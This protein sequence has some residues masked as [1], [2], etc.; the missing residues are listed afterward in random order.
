MSGFPQTSTSATS[1]L[2]ADNSSS[3]GAVVQHSIASKY[4]LTP[5][6][7]A[8]GLPID[9]HTREPDDA[10][11]NPDPL[12]DR[13]VDKG[14]HIFTARGLGNLGCLFIIAAGFLTLFAG[15]PIFSHFT[16]HKQ[17]TQ[18]AFNLGGTNA[19]GQ[20]PL[21]SGNFALIDE[22]T[23]KDAYTKASYET[24]EEW[25]LVFSDEFN[26]DGRSFYAGDDPFW[27]AVDFHYWGTNDLEWYDPGQI[28]TGG[29]SLLI[30][31]EQ[32]NPDNN[33]NLAYKNKFCFTGGLIE[34]AVTLPGSNTVGGLWPA[35]WAMGNLGR[36]GYGGSLDGMWPYTY[37]SCDVGTLPNQTFPGTS[38]PVAAIQNGDPQYDNVLSFLPGQRLSACTCPGESHPGPM[39]KNGT[40]VGRSAPEID[41]LE[42]IVDPDGGKVSLSAQWGPYNAG[43][44]WK[45][46]TDNLIIYDTTSTV[47]NQYKGGVYQ[48][49]TSGLALANQNCYEL[50]TKCFAIYGFEYKPGFDDAYITWINDGK[51]SWTLRAPGMAGDTLT[52]INARPVSQ[53]PMYI[54]ANLGISNNFGVLDPA[55]T[56]PTTMRID[57]IRVY[58]PKDALNVGCDPEDFPTADYIQTYEDVYTNPNITTWKEAKQPWPKNSLQNGGTC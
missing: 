20:V 47:L 44:N 58:Q 7:K 17:T 34:T 55:L 4:S 2:L 23:P 31:L 50:N 16:Q 43:Y 12:R 26:T 54:I 35:V 8:W 51:K 37:D 30:K 42:A 27:E 56:F 1:L 39:R 24:G 41:I 52:Q 15:Y 19:S 25:E 29:G 48:Q 46:N 9:I 53:E 10:L 28:T 14:G 33:H 18:G 11:H 49:T 5:S 21:M 36:A 13:R 32:A 57:Y 6:P 22:D 3:P 38:T 45:N 40:Y